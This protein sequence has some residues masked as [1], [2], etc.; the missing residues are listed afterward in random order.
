MPGIP[1]AA[2]GPEGDPAGEAAGDPDCEAA[3]DPEG[4]AAGDPAARAPGKPVRPRR[5]NADTATSA[6]LAGLVRVRCVGREACIVRPLY[7]VEGVSALR[8]RRRRIW[9]LM[10]AQRPIIART[11]STTTARPTARPMS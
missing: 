8:R 9:A 5:L 2:G 7:V 3:G 4:E 1:T 11:T 6:A 10:S